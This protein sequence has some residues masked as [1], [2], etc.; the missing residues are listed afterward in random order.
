[1]VCMSLSPITKHAVGEVQ[2]RSFQVVERIQARSQLRS[3]GDAKSLLRRNAT[4]A[5][6]ALVVVQN[7]S[8]QREEGSRGHRMNQDIHD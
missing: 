7:S 6:D 1:M 2:L 3:T 4:A 8:H 5:Q